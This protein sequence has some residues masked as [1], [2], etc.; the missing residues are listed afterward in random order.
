MKWISNSN[1]T[2]RSNAKSF[3]YSSAIIT[4]D[5]Y[6]ISDR[7]YTFPVIYGYP[8]ASFTRI[9]YVELFKTFVLSDYYAYM[10]KI[11]KPKI[12]KIFPQLNWKPV[13]PVIRKTCYSRY[14]RL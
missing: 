14:S 3:P 10:F 9:I 12:F 8:F 4:V 6:F 7:A 5:F 11:E 13:F 1:I 2:I